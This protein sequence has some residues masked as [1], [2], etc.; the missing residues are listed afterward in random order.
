MT[1]PY[2]FAA[3]TRRHFL[4][5]GGAAIAAVA[6]AAPL[7]AQTDETSLVRRTIICRM[8]NSPDRT[9]MPWLPRNPDSVWGPGDRQR[10]DE[11]LSNTPSISPTRRSTPAAGRARS[12]VRD[13]PVSTTMAGVEMRLTAGGI[14]ELHWHVSAEWA[15]MIYGEARIT[16]VDADGKSFVNDVKAGDL[17]LFPGGVSA[18]H[19]GSRSRRMQVSAGL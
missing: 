1:E 10:H 15:F 4:S 19:P 12:T 11:S 7:A 2:P 16:A 17:W 14:R 3:V 6:A 5:V 8:S 18:L 13:L 9:T